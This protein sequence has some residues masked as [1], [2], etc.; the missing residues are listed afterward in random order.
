MISIYVD[1]VSVTVQETET[2]TAGRVGLECNVSFGS[3]LWGG[4]VKKITFDGAEEKTLLLTDS[5]VT[6][7]W[8]CLAE[9]GHKVRV[10]ICGENA[11][12]T[13][14]V[15]TLWADLGKIKAAAPRDGEDPEEPTPSVIAQ[16]QQ[17]ASSANATSSSA[18]NMIDG[19]TASGVPSGTV[20]VSVSDEGDHKHL[21]FGI[22]SPGAFPSFDDILDRPKYKGSEMTSE[23]AIPEVKTAL[24]DS[25]AAGN[26][27]HDTRY[28]SKA[29]TDSL[30]EDKADADSLPTKVSDLMNDSGFITEA[31]LDGKENVNN[32]VL[33]ISASSTDTQY[34]SAKCVY[35]AINAMY[36][37]IIQLITSGEESEF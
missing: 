27:N 10:G 9:E 31:D 1:N 36:G 18:L 15:P 11:D 7:P 33:S 34:P 22:P 32:K 29:D 25:K 8:E 3:G 4:L 23:T 6:I 19:L 13:I 5:V 2:L 21:E 35:E 30:L 16:I 28:Y 26:H 17:L 24:W 14:V 20:Y 37:K 12:G